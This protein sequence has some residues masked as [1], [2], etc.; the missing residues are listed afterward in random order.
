VF[1]GS[2]RCDKHSVFVLKLR[3]DAGA[4][5]TYPHFIGAL[6]CNGQSSGAESGRAL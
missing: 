6:F 1:V 2:D 3:L 5:R 4:M